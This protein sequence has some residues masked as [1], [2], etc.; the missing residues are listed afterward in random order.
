[1]LGECIDSFQKY[2]ERF[3]RVEVTGTRKV[4]TP[5][6]DIKHDFYRVCK[7][8]MLAI[9]PKNTVRTIWDA[10]ERG[11]GNSLLVAYISVMLLGVVITSY[12]T[13]IMNQ[14]VNH[15]KNRDVDKMIFEHQQ[16]EYI[17]MIQGLITM[18]IV[19]EVFSTVIYS[20]IG[21]ILLTL[22][23]KIHI[24]NILFW[25]N[26]WY[27][28]LEFETRNQHTYDT[29]LI[30]I[31]KYC[32]GQNQLLEWGVR[33]SLNIMT[34]LLSG[35]IT[36]WSNPDLAFFV[37]MVNIVNSVINWLIIKNNGKRF[38]E[39]NDK[40]NE[41]SVDIQIKSNDMQ[42]NKIEPDKISKPMHEKFF[43]YN[44]VYSYYAYINFIFN[45]GT[46]LTVI[47]IFKA[48]TNSVMYSIY[49]IQILKSVSRSVTGIFNFAGSWMEHQVNIIEFIDF[50]EE[51]S[52]KSHP[53]PEQFPHP[54]R[55]VFTDLCI[56]YENNGG[57][58]LVFHE[59]LNK[60]VVTQGCNILTRGPSGHGKSSLL[61]VIQGKMPGITIS[62][63][64]Y[65]PKNFIKAICEVPQDS[66]ISVTRA[67]L[68]HLFSKDGEVDAKDGEVESKDGEVDAKDGEVDSKD[69]E[70]DSKDGEVD[71]HLMKECLQM[72]EMWEWVKDRKQKPK[73]KN[74]VEEQV[75]WLLSKLWNILVVIGM[76]E[77]ATSEAKTEEPDIE[78]GLANLQFE[79]SDLEPY[80][81]DYH[82]SAT[83]RSIIDKGYCLQEPID[84][85]I[86]GGQARRLLLAVEIYN[87]RRN[88][89]CRWI[90]FDEPESGSDPPLAYRVIW[91]II[92]KFDELNKTVII[93]S[94]LE[95]IGD[96]IY[97]NR[98]SI[99]DYNLWVENGK[100]G[101]A[102][103]ECG[104]V[105]GPMFK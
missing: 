73:K 69:G 48:D 4:T 14:I 77:E 5:S 20:F 6:Y 7:R 9:A 76:V 8:I 63:S 18:Y 78:T 46:L 36:M 22:A 34:S 49:A 3:F 16:A 45:V 23:V 96:M 1:M 91:N 28:S 47:Y 42:Y 57:F 88:P 79:V 51:L 39:T 71:F 103:P 85:K 38:K 32:K 43:L 35:V 93:V 67:T 98:S 72:T 25:S 65:Q 62:N 19:T 52:S 29:V 59:S 86:S 30:K 31:Q 87:A 27:S 75:N 89:N 83:A 56:T 97:P 10:M 101:H 90:V 44:D 102:T 100:V 84:N 2:L 82:T 54:E 55:L 12:G 13:S 24:K 68:K 50:V 95:R 74:S 26:N 80:E 37:L 41:L 40:Y 94:H 64:P 17:A 61:N 99:W 92:Q 58:Q 11:K 105:S 33:Q 60:I 70:V 15:E 21:N 81:A 104:R 53:F 66:P